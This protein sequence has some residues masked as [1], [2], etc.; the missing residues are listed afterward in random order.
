M[1]GGGNIFDEP[2]HQELLQDEDPKK[3]AAFEDRICPG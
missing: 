3:L 2:K 1:Y